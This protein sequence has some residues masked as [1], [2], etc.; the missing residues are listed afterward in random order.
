M[1]DQ[2]DKTI[3]A[4]GIPSFENHQPTHRQRLQAMARTPE[5]SQLLIRR[6]ALARWR[7]DVRLPPEAPSQQSVANEYLQQRNAERALS[8]MVLVDEEVP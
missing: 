6:E 5:W 2:E 1:T 4:Q 7:A 3:D 8:G